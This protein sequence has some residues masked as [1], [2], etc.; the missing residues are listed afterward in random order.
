MQTHNAAP[1]PSRIDSSRNA[2]SYFTAPKPPPGDEPFGEVMNRALTQADD[3]RR[4][5][6]RDDSSPE[7]SVQPAFITRA[8]SDDDS[9]DDASEIRARQNKGPRTDEKSDDKKAAN[10]PLMAIMGQLPA[11][12]LAPTVAK[13]GKD[14]CE[15]APG[16][17]NPVS[18]RDGAL[19]PSAPRSAAQSDDANKTQIATSHDA[20]A[21]QADADAIKPKTAPSTTAPSD[22]AKLKEDLDSTS[23]E[24]SPNAPDAASASATPQQAQSAQGKGPAPMA[25]SPP[26]LDGIS[27]AKQDMTM[28]KNEKTLKIAEAAEQDLPGNATKGS[29]EL[30]GGQKLS[31]KAPAH[32]STNLESNATVDSAAA[33]RLT[34]IE[35]T[36][37]TV[38]TE[39]A[40]S[41]SAIDS[42][43]LE[44]THDI[45]AL[46][47]MRLGETGAQSLHVVVKPGASVQLSL[48][49]RKGENGIEVHAALHKGDFEQMNQHWPELQ[50]R[51]EARGVRVGNLTTSE[52]F[53][54]TSEHHFQQSKQPTTQ[55]E[56]LYAGAFAEFALAG[57]MTDT[58]AARAA[59]ASAYRGWE[60]WA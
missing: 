30:P 15:S 57:S 16:A 49:L 41:A 55:D 51:L 9:S 13:S 18:G 23:A 35:S 25:A 38:S 37:Q 53:S 26:A 34:P 22:A 43:V 8:D 59:R 14:S 40:S 7:N 24:T 39:A 32:G 28:Q 11:P 6:E 10:S 48:E 31:A 58:A 42:R 3:R 45:V 2:D 5:A 12:S 46:H 21:A 33:N 50:Q 47:A 20:K 44:R 52:N 56:P 19:A 4:Q 54:S 17:A 60:T 29:E 36:T 27:A 1:L